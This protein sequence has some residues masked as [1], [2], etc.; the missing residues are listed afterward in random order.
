M[1]N[2]CRI[3]GRAAELGGVLKVYGTRWYLTW[4]V[5]RRVG[6]DVGGCTK[7]MT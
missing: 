3:W 4:C 1:D 7:F 2:L 6:G 5:F